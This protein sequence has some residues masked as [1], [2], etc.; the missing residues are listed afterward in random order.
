[1]FSIVIPLFNN[2]QT[3]E[4]ALKSVINQ[5]FKKFETI[6]VDDGST[7]NGIEII[8]KFINYDQ[9]KIIK[10]KNQ[11]ASIARNTG[12]VKAQNKYIAFLD[13]DDEWDPKYL[14]NVHQAIKLNPNCGM[15]CCARYG[16]DNVTKNTNLIIAE[17]YKGKL[18]EINYFENPHIFSHTSSTVVEKNVFNQ[19]GGFN[20]EQVTQEDLT[21]FALVAL[22][23]AT[24]Y[25]G[26]P[27]SYYYGNVE[28]QTTSR[29]K[30]NY[31]K[32]I[33]ACKRFNL[34]YKLWNLRGRDN[35]I[36]KI[37]LKYEFRHYIIHALRINDFNLIK[38]ILENIDGD[39]L[40]LFPFFEIKFYRMPTLKIWN[41]FYILITKFF[42]RIR[43]FPRVKKYNY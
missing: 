9:L 27:L 35:K 28:G 15:V 26:L 4:R 11:G 25:C 24:I 14:E 7:D 19:V 36:F 13:A 41:K 18:L 32:N 33:D 10:Q 40:N 12:V 21:L 43:G 22:T 2:A 6:V 30:D 37:F 1:M 34:T 31:R 16:K 17:K 8:N 3:I 39:I 38:V 5:T 23:K 42:W 29:I 20:K